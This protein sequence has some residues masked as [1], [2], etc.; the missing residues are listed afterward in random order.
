M[1]PWL[2]WKRISVWTEIVWRMTFLNEIIK[3][4]GRSIFKAWLVDEITSSIYYRFQTEK[5]NFVVRLVV[6]Y[7]HTNIRIRIETIP[8]LQLCLCHSDDPGIT[9]IIIVDSAK[10]FCDSRMGRTSN[11]VPHDDVAFSFFKFL[12]AIKKQINCWLI[13]H[14]FLLQIKRAPLGNGQ[15][16]TWQLMCT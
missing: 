1:W 4:Y 5:S 7:L 13:Q 8:L 15:T 2:Q 14:T 12:N 16:T 3:I 6:W 11:G 9:I 10:T